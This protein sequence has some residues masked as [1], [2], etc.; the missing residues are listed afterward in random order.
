MQLLSSLA[1][2]CRYGIVASVFNADQLCTGLHSCS[3]HTC[4]QCVLYK[5]QLLLLLQSVTFRDSFTLY[6]SVTLSLIYLGTSECKFRNKAQL[7]LLPHFNCLSIIENSYTEGA[8][9]FMVVG[10]LK[11]LCKE[12]TTCPSGP[13][14]ELF[15]VHMRQED[16]V[17]CRTHKAQLLC[18][19]PPV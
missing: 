3:L 1:E 14:V 4:K 5:H 12:N 2:G 17:T 8:Y 19:F 18:K 13:R 7:L 10:I 11:R 6:L 9:S 15:T 16:F